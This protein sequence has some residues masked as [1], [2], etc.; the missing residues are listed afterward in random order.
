[1]F[2]KRTRA[3]ADAAAANSVHIE[4]FVLIAALRKPSG[5]ETVGGTGIHHLRVGT[6]AHDFFT[7]RHGGKQMPSGASA[8]DYHPH[9][10]AG[11]LPSASSAPKAAIAMTIA[12]P[13]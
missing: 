10:T 6:L 5:L 11:R 12:V 9:L 2:Q 13:P 7:E 8:C 4:Q 3:R 1:E